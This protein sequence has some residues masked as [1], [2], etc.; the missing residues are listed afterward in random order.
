MF[1]NTKCVGEVKISFFYKYNE[2]GQP[3]VA[4]CTITSK[5]NEL[6]AEGVAA[7]SK[8]DQFQ[9]K[10][11]RKICLQ[12]A[13]KQLPLSQAERKLVWD[14]FFENTKF[15]KATPEWLNAKKLPEK[16]E[17]DLTEFNRDEVNKIVAIIN[18]K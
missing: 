18:K 5:D 7:V 4:M 17:V 9:R 15:G 13:L 6:L 12:R 8:T 2:V 14:K 1:V 3:K 10:F 11:G 16:I